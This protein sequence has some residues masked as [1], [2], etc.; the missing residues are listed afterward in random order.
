MDPEAIALDLLHFLTVG[1]R[2]EERGSNVWLV[3]PNDEAVF[4]GFADIDGIPCVTPLQTYL[5]LKG[6]P[7]RSEEA[8]EELRNRMLSWNLRGSF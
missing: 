1:I 3:Q 4:H 6:H 8:A 7:E 2:W 5:D